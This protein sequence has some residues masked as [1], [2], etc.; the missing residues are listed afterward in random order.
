MGDTKYTTI[1]R[2]LPPEKFAEV[3]ASS[4]RQARET[5]FHRH[6]VRASKKKRLPRPGQKAQ[7]RTAALYELLRSEDDDEMAEEV[8]RKKL[9][10]AQQA[11]DS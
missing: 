1:L 5:Y 7:E 10:A 8:L 6:G 4:S 2:E 11:P 3:F 9:A